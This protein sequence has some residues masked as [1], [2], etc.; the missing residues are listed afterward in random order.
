[1]TLKAVMFV[2]S[3]LRK[4]LRKQVKWSL[5]DNEKEKQGIKREIQKERY[6]SAHSL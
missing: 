3:K 1:M 6:G 5:E 2:S 4:Y